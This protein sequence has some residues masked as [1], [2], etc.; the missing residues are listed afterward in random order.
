M[1][2][3]IAITRARATTPRLKPSMAFSLLNSRWMSVNH[4][5][6]RSA[7]S[8]EPHNPEHST[9]RQGYHAA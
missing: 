8:F 6:L 5:V 3:D 4:T 2:Q 7:G 9:N 1:K